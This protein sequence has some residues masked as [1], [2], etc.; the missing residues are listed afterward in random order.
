EEGLGGERLEE[1]RDALV[2][3][4]DHRGDHHHDHHTDGDTQDGQRR[5]P[6]VREQ[7]RERDAHPFEQSSHVS[8]R[9]AAIGSR[10][11]ARLAG[12][13]PATMPTPAPRMTP[14]RID[15]AATA[16]GR[17]GVAATGAASARP[18]ATPAGAP[19]VASVDA[20]TRQSRTV[21]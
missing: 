2:D 19:T 10:R 12:Y 20:S 15:Q 21:G 6:L 8:C 13:T 14:T 3:A 9:N 4:A 7:R 1:V 11:A 16:A 18:A 17:G 5:P